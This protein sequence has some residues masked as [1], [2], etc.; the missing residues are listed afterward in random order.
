MSGRGSGRHELEGPKAMV[1]AYPAVD[2]RA[3][4]RLPADDDRPAL[5]LTVEVEARLVMIS[6]EAAPDELGPKA[7]AAV[8]ALQWTPC[9]YGGERA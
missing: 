7:S 6:Y 8:V 3:R 4:Q 9:T 2:V 5:T 1:A